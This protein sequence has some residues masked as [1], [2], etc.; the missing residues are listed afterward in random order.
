MADEGW[1]Y[2]HTNGDLIWKNGAYTSADDLHD[3]DFVVRFWRFRDGDRELGWTTLVEALAAGANRHRVRELADLWGM[4]DD[5]AH[6]FC[7]RVDVTVARERDGWF[8]VPS[9]PARAAVAMSLRRDRPPPPP[10]GR[11]PTILDALAALARAAGWRPSKHG[12]SFV[13]H[14][15]RQERPAAATAGPKAQTTTN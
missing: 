1:Y 7:R 14:L 15:H 10:V 12:A 8:V 2:L 4:G 5:D 6:E 11:G 3:S 9:L 13:D